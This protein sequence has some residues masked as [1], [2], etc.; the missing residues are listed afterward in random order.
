MRSWPKGRSFNRPDGQM[1][2]SAVEEVKPSSFC[3]GEALLAG[4]TRRRLKEGPKTQRRDLGVSQD[5]LEELNQVG[6]E[7]KASLFRTDGWMDMDIIH[8]SVHL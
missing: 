1:G 5:P 2:G 8:E 4:P 3:L 7:R 6:M